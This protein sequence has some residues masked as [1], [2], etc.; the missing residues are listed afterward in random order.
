M[1][2]IIKASKFIL[3]K[4]SSSALV[5]ADKNKIIPK[6]VVI[7]NKTSALVKSD[8]KTSAIVKSQSSENKVKPQISL[9]KSGPSKNILHE[10][11]DK[12][13]QIDDLLKSNLKLKKKQ[14]EKQ[15]IKSEQKEFQEREEKLEK[16]KGIKVPSLPRA[17]GMFG[18]FLE[19]IKRWIFFTALGWVF[20]KFF[21]HL[22][23]L[24]GIVKLIGK[25]YQFTEGLFK[26]FLSGLVTF[27]SKG[28]EMYD[29]TV[30]W[31]KDIGGEKFGQ[32]FDNFEKTLTKF[33]DL[34]IVASLLG[35]DVGLSALDEFKKQKRKGA[36]P[37]VPKGGKPPKGASPKGKPPKGASPKGK[38][39]KGK[40]PS[41]WNRIFK[42]PFAKL[43]GPLSKFAGSV[44]PGVGAVVG[45]MDANQR[46]ASGDKLGGTLA[47]ISATLDA[48]TAG[49]AIL[50]LTGIGAIAPAAFATVSMGIDVILLIRDILKGFNVP[51]FAKG[52]QVTRGG[53]VVGGG[54]SR[55]GTRTSSKIIK[56]TKKSQK[57]ATAPGKDVG[58]DSKIKAIFPDTTVKESKKSAQ[59]PNVFSWFGLLF[60]TN[61]KD[62]EKN[63]ENQNEISKIKAPNAFKVITDASK[64]Y[65]N[66]GGFVGQLAGI[67][68]DSLLG[69]KPTRTSYK[70]ISQGILG[71]FDRIISN[72][73]GKGSIE[74]Q[75]TI[76]AYISG[77]IVSGIEKQT[78]N[79]S[80]TLENDLTKAIEN[81]TDKGVNKT[82]S[83]IRK[84]GGKN[85]KRPIAGR[86]ELMQRNREG[87]TQGIDEDGSVGGLTTGKWGPLLDLIAGKE[88]G[89]NYEA[90][91]PSTTLP[92]ATKMTI[93]EVARR[94]TGAVGK[95]QQLPQYLVGRAKSAGLNPDKDLYSPQNQEK[96]I[97]NVN[98]KGRGGEKWLRNEISDEQFMQG[99]SQEFASLP[100]A[101]G[102][103]YYPG[104]RS[105]MTPQRVKAA[106]SKVKKGGYSKQ[107]LSK[108]GDIE[109]GKGY[110]KEGSK[111]AGELG[112]FIKKH[113]KQGPDFSQVH[114][115]PEHPPFSLSSGHSR[116]S[117]H[118]QGRAIDIGAYTHEQG[119]I[120]KAIEK[121]NKM[122]GVK[123]VQLLHG[124]NEP[125]G[126]S[127]HV[128]VAYEKGGET[129]SKPH[130]ALVAEKGTEYVIDADSYRA[131][132]KVAPGLLDILNYKVN[133][134]PSL[135]KNIPAIISSL[136][137]GL[138]LYND[139]T[140]KDVKKEP[141]KLSKTPN[142]GMPAYATGGPTNKNKNVQA[143]KITA[144][145]YNT[146]LA[147]AAL[148]DDKPQGRADV[149]Q[150]LYNRILAANQYN[151]N[152]NQKNNTLKGLITAPQQYEPTFTNT[153][154]WLNI[155]DK[156]T[157]ALAIMNSKKGKTHKW[158]LKNAMDQ[159]NATEAALKNP[160]LQM[161]SQK[162]VGGRAYF[163][164]T[165][166]HGNIKPGDVLR[167]PKS[168]FF[169]PW[170]L[171]GTEYDKKRRNVASPI[172]EMLL[173]K[174]GA[175]TAKTG[176]KQPSIIDRLTNLGKDFGKNFMNMAGI[177]KKEGG[178]VVGD[179]NPR[180]PI[181]D[182]YASYE[183]PSRKNT[184]ALQR[185]YIQVPTQSENVHKSL[186]MPA[187]SSV[188]SNKSYSPLSRS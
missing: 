30:K 154:D 131:T 11:R 188:N 141:V 114:R 94:A 20:N 89:G 90:M 105:S 96:I 27:V 39:P 38:P 137:K 92:G 185:V 48:W 21:K 128:H 33:I 29:S 147:I 55:G 126:H 43:K 170:Y 58:G 98:I 173:P 53:K 116:G 142:I 66:I 119:P 44:V 157:A 145:D 63:K 134:I 28:M 182:S 130:M 97:I 86:E 156:K 166:Q 183:N 187:P 35:I 163:L 127:D 84:E 88:S 186:G 102:N 34:S 101:Q 123:P 99:L 161:Q 108:S 65:K 117:L 168:N 83:N 112:R 169:S 184:V 67:V 155:T 78:A 176:V 158:N 111:I 150:S 153:N 109:L 61:T 113:L 162:H 45:A 5:K 118:Y 77:G 64:D 121:F 51:V 135:V 15:R 47:S 120:L 100:N 181:P 174:K 73:V 171:E 6:R 82:I 149:A 177:K 23:K 40:T 17:G 59:R 46:F 57:S 42:G 22:P 148:E 13:I 12:V 2:A 165:S 151:V 60:P 93:S 159:L 24:I 85:S 133:D 95:Y 106:L 138:T 68:I 115:H 75:N 139:K 103:F 32:N 26:N 19:K 146:L 3:S 1:A 25:V 104:Q 69:Q 152:F 122:M 178:G 143:P 132:E 136:S 179:S 56:R 164:G 31:V 124:K 91:Y 180:L 52:G 14:S 167:D 110:G 36:K 8:K 71:L 9:L 18:G 16:P 144:S 125:S 4:K 10:I 37:P 140:E 7:G 74:L 72:K 175:G 160:A 54:I 79:L 129:K 87:Y 49:T 70:A 80:D 41:F 107:E 172:P 50:A 76:S 62:P 81:L